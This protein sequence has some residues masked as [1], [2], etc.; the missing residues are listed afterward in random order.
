MK[1][2]LLKVVKFISAF[3]WASIYLIISAFTISIVFAADFGQTPAKVYLFLL[4][5]FGI[6]LIISLAF[7]F[8][9]LDKIGQWLYIFVFSVFPMSFLICGL[10]NLPNLVGILGSIL[11]SLVL[12]LFAFI[13]VFLHYKNK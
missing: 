3:F 6:V 1:N 10:L 2:D 13:G 12:S 8:W 5:L 9:G 4:A 7:L 11:I